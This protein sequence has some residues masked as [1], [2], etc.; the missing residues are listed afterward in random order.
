[1]PIEILSYNVNGLVSK[2]LF[3]EFFTFVKSYEIFFLFET[4]VTEEKII[5]YNKYFGEFELKSIAATKLSRFGRASGGC[6]YGYKKKG[7]WSKYLEFA[8]VE[9][10]DVLVF[11]SNSNKLIFLPTYLNC[12]SWHMDFLTLSSALQNS[13][14]RSLVIVGDLNARVGSCQTVDEHIPLGNLNLEHNRQS[15]DPVL[16]P[17]GKRILELFDDVGIIILNGRSRSDRCGELTFLGSMGSSINDIC[18]VSLSALK[19]VHDFKVLSKSFSDHMPIVLSLL[20]NSIPENFMKLLPK[21]NWN[22][23]NVDTYKSKISDLLNGDFNH[24]CIEHVI[25]AI[26]SA[27]GYDNMKK[28]GKKVFKSKWFDNDCLSSRRQMFKLLNL[29]RRYNT[30]E[31]KQMYLDA[32]KKYKELCKTKKTEYWG[33]FGT[34]LLLIRDSK[35]WWATVREMQNKTFVVGNSVKL[36]EFVVHFRRLF[37][38]QRAACLTFYA[39]P[40]ILNPVLDGDFEVNEILAVIYKMKSGKAPGPDRIPAEFFKNAPLLMINKL[41]EIFDD[42]LN[43]ERAPEHFQK[44]I[45][46]PL[47]KKGDANDVNNYRAIT[48]MNTV[49]KIFAGVMNNRLTHWLEENSVLR[50]CQA[51]FRKGYSTV[52]NIFNLCAI[53]SLKLN[54]NRKVYAFFVDFKSAFDCIDREALYYKLSVAGISTKFIHIIKAI[55]SDTKVAIWDGNGMSEYF[56]TYMGVKQGCILSP[57][58]FSIFLNDL[59][60]TLYGGLLINNKRIN[61]LMYADDIVLLAESPLVLNEMIRRLENYCHRWNLVV[62]L[63][64]S[65]IM[66]FRKGG[67]LSAR[68]SWKFNNNPLEVVPSYK[69]LGIELTV[70]LSFQQHLKTKLQQAKQA[71]NVTWGK[72]LS[73]RDVS[74]ETKFKLFDSVV[75]AVLC[76]SAQVWGFKKYQEVEMLL[77]FFIKRLFHLPQNTP[78]YMVHLE[79]GIQELYTHTL[80]L[81]LS[82]LLRCMDLPVSRFPSFLVRELISKHVWCVK[83]FEDIMNET[84]V[85]VN[86]QNYDNEGW[87]MKFSE[88]IEKLV[89]LNWNSLVELGKTSSHD[90]Y[91][92]LSY[93]E[94]TGYSPLQMSPHMFMTIFK[95]RGGLLN[96]NSCTFSRGTTGLCSLCNL[97]EK[98]DTYHFIAL[99]P[100][101]REMRIRHFE[102]AFLTKEELRSY[103]NGPN[104][105]IIYN[106]INDAM[107]YRLYLTAEF[108]I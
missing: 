75:R 56:G 77:R 57:I 21:I 78:N 1:M 80:R 19:L 104:W 70:R 79:T 42:I 81:H 23:Q 54:S 73:K 29:F 101:L 107:Q 17:N 7:L 48:C 24:T 22:N 47:F 43:S 74:L 31:L 27:S 13:S 96:L 25:N 94:L 9:N 62:N 60:E 37:N 11:K 97:H 108:N 18:G 69:Y 106:Y 99:C 46:I 91:G 103:L 14:E 38:P 61:L 63:S 89:R 36:N 59:S 28:A 33:S 87:C 86:L 34:R 49:A 65:K 102:T 93:G 4:H 98:E 95:A 26:Y 92:N 71:I 5:Q 82:Y 32:N 83:E 67:R 45:V 55:Y 88:I 72:L 76:Y 40:N 6:L 105:Q 35:E 50:E 16:N 41:K 90:E 3:P 8:I 39:E 85:V 64:K 53:V 51:G 58:L 20:V 10:V 84:G 15:K 66:V 12:N 100:V 44:A 52:D 68:E 2:L 30:D